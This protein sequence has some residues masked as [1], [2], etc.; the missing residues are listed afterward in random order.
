[1]K[2]AFESFVKLVTE[3]DEH[4][5]MLVENKAGR[6]YLTVGDEKSRRRTYRPARPAG[7]GGE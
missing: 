3:K 5:A 6:A 2:T 4:T 7:R 1:M